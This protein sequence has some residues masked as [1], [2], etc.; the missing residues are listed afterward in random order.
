MKDSCGFDIVEGLY[1]DDLRLHY[2]SIKKTPEG[3]MKR[4]S[5]EQNYSLLNQ[6]LASVLVRLP[7]SDELTNLILSVEK[8][9]SETE[10]ADLELEIRTGI[11]GGFSQ[12]QPK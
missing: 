11:L 3:F 8:E 4:E 5:D 12:S 10:N 6:Y 7:H 1:E 9:R 2:Y